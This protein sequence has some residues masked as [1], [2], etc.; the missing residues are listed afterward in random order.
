LASNKVKRV[1]W[2]ACAWLGLI[3]NEAARHRQLRMIW[4]S[5]SQGAYEIWTSTFTYAEVFKA[6][7]EEGD[8]TLA[9]ESDKRIDEMME[10]P[11]VKRVQ[12]DV[13]T[14]RLARQL[15]REHPEL[16][17]P[18]DAI[19][20]ATAIRQNVDALHTYD[21]SNLIKLDGKVRKENGDFL[22]ICI[23][24]DD[25]DGPLFAAKNKNE[26]KA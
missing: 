19:H 12:V 24:D 16:K 14:G 3:N 13:P 25:S 17:K 22:L 20:L 26:K 10:Q 23:P 6:K 21:G 7:C 9:A 2:D 11:F 4:D 18:Q 1:Y 15:L 8:V 5:A